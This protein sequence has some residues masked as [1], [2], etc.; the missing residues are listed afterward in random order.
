MAVWGES[1]ASLR[2]FS[3]LFG[4]LTVVLMGV[5]AGELYRASSA[6]DGPEADRRWFARFVALLVAISPFQAFYSAEARMYPFGTAFTALGALAAAA[7]PPRPG[8]GAALV[9]VRGGLHRHALHPPLRVVHRRRLVP[10][11]GALRRLAPGRAGAAGGPRGR[12]RSRE[13]GGR[14]RGGLS[15]GHGAAP[16]AGPPGP[17][18]LLDPPDDLADLLGDVQPVPAGDPRVRFPDRGL[19]RLR[20]PRPG[21]PRRP[22]SAAGGATGWSWRR[23]WRPSCSP[24]ASRRSSRSGTT[25]ISCSRTCS[26]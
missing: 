1:V 17:P 18:G 20:G 7:G 25:S 12:R 26:C 10:L 15:A 6:G 23:R 8:A 5:F 16:G 11:P 2:G 4:V 14:A 9:G 24:P 3:V 13:G 21:V 19:G 22:R